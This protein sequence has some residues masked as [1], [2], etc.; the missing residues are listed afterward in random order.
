MISFL[1]GKQKHKAQSKVL[2][3]LIA[4]RL[5]AW[6]PLGNALA[7]S[8]V[9]LDP[10]I[11]HICIRYSV[12][13]T[14]KLWLCQSVL[15]M[16]HLLHFCLWEDWIVYSVFFFFQA[17]FVSINMGSFSS[18]ESRGLRTE[19]VFHCTHCTG[20]IIVILGYINTFDLNWFTGLSSAPVSTSHQ[21][22]G[23]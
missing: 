10:H 7:C 6:V 15:Y 12:N 11:L 4:T 14:C 23:S 18:I 9:L 3:C 8:V 22:S 20:N 5:L 16:Q 19:D 17:P 1:G 13:A 2:K 21:A